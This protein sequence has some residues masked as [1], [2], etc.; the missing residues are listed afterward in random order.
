MVS[1]LHSL[2]VLGYRLD[3]CQSASPISGGN[4]PALL[5]ITYVN[6]CKYRAIW[7]APDRGKLANFPATGSIEE[8][9]CVKRIKI[10]LLPYETRVTGGSRVGNRG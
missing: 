6:K 9:G 7:G 8:K 2:P 4:G 10:A 1:L 3:S 5:Y